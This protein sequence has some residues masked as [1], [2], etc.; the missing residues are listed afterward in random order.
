[1]LGQANCITARG[2]I[3]LQESDHDTARD[4][5]N[6]AHPLFEQ[7]GDVLGQ[8]NCIRSLGDIAL[9]QSDHDTARGAYNQAHP[10]YEQIGDLLGQANCITRLG[11]I[12]LAR[13]DHDA[14]RHAYD[15]ALALYASISEPYSIGTTHARLARVSPDDSTRR[16][17]VK[18]ARGAWAGIGRADLVEWLDQEFGDTP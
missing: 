2:D 7:I 13:S 15:D 12:A 10:L 14:A 9:Q 11:D 17:H 5:Y 8:A 1:V 18:A 16:A 3:A 6:R 4:A